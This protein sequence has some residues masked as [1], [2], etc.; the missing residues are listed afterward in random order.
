MALREESS[1]QHHLLYNTKFW[2]RQKR[3]IRMLL[4]GKREK[5]FLK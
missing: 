1:H 4:V 3:E 2:E 5:F